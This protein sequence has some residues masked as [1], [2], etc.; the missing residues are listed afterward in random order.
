MGNQDQED[1]SCG[2]LEAGQPSPPHSPAAAADAAR[3]KRRHY[4]IR[5]AIRGFFAGCG[6]VIAV[7]M[8]AISLPYRSGFSWAETAVILVL[9]LLLS[10]LVGFM[11]FVVTLEWDRIPH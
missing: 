5:D 10:V 8:L 4:A 9:G 3:R 1:I 2:L 11:G 6:L 7:F